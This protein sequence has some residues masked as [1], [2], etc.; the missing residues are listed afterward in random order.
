MYSDSGLF[1]HRLSRRL[2]LNDGL[3]LLK[4][5]GLVTGHV[6]SRNWSRIHSFSIVKVSWSAEDPIF[7][8]DLRWSESW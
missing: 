3:D 4:T 6:G 7:I 1:R 5:G 8:A 2:H